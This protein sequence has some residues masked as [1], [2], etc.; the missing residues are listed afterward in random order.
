MA[1]QPHIDQS[2]L[3]PHEQASSRAHEQPVTEK[4]LH[5]TPVVDDTE[6]SAQ[7]LQDGVKGIEAISQ[8]WT[9]VGL[10]VAYLGIFLM[11]FVT[12]LEGQVTGSVTI[13]VTSSFSQHS[14]VSTINV[15]Q[16]VILTIVKPPMA[17][18]ADVF[19]R[20]EAFCLSVLLFVLGFIAMACS[21]NVQTFAAAQ[22]FYS[23]GSTGLQ[24]LQQVFVADTTD[25]SWR[26]IMSTLPDLPFLVTTWVGVAISDRIRE[27]TGSWRWCYGMFAVLLPAAFLPLLTSLVANGLKA[28]RMGLLPPKRQTMQGGPLAVLGN[29]WRDLDV[30]GMILLGAGFALILVPCTIAANVSGGWSNRSIIAMVTVGAV[31]VVIYPF[32]EASSRFAKKHNIQGV[33]GKIMAN[34]A[35]HPL[36]PLYLL[37]SRT[38]SAGC[39]LVFFYFMAFYLSVYPYF[40]SYLL[41][42]RGLPNQTA[43]YVT[44]TFTFSSTVSSIIVSILIKLT[45]RYKWFVVG[46]SA[47]YMMGM[48]L[49]MHYRTETASLS[50][51]IGSQV[52]LGF[53]GGMLNVPAQIGVQASASH[54]DLGS[55]TA[56]FLTIVSIGSAV[57]SAISGAV[58]GQNIVP[59]LNEYLPDAAKVNATLIYSDIDEALAYPQGSDERIAINRAYQETMTKLLTI[60]VCVCAPIFVF[61]LLMSDYHLD[62]IQQGVRGLVIG[63][64][65]GEDSRKAEGAKDGNPY[66]PKNW[67]KR[68]PARVA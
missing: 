46:G 35:P 42:V 26:A 48:G 43:V 6:S 16:S 14:L 33:P 63:G 25:L 15:V 12:S 65:V 53:G 45:L 54:Q 67:F 50:A 4:T 24:I 60:A 40:Q 21:N 28:K 62:E 22:I 1:D 47:L 64:D 32:W 38:F 27:E 58:W 17:K 57:G 34:T 10:G 29:L 5:E 51:I 41:V 23:S 36:T 11:A 56:I 30:G 44:Q 20:T 52:L 49:M 18:I 59:K 3:Q 9:K 7:S 13:F 55:A 68:R 19:G 61:S 37:K 8:S 31:L 66:N 2:S 39:V